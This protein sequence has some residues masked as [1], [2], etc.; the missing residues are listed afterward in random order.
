MNKWG[1]FLILSGVSGSLT[2]IE[3]RKKSYSFAQ[4]SADFEKFYV[5]PGWIIAAFVSLPLDD[6][7]KAWELFVTTLRVSPK[8]FFVSGTEV[9]SEKKYREPF[10]AHCEKYDGFLNSLLIDVK[11]KRLI[12]A[13]GTEKTQYLKLPGIVTVFQYWQ[14]KKNT[15]YQHFYA[16]YFDTLVIQLYETITTAYREHDTPDYPALYKKAKQYN[17][18]I[19]A[20]FKKLRGGEYDGRYAYHLKRYKEV[21]AILQ[22]ERTLQEGGPDAVAY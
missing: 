11:N 16:F 22:K 9:Y 1:L 17:V 20:L 6:F 21:L 12:L 2:P 3:E 5:D 19:A 18:M 10:I 15:T 7:D 14:A 4:F 8:K 13:T